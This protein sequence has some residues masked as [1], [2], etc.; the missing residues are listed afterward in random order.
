MKM[1]PTVT[2]ILAAALLAGTTTTAAGARSADA[3]AQADRPTVVLVHGAFE[4][5]TAWSYVTRRLQASGY[6]VIA[7]AVP[8]RGVGVDVAYLDSM[9]HTVQGPIV[10]VGHSYGGMLVSG[11]AALNSQVAALVYVAAFIPETGE[12]VGG[13]NSQFPGSTLGPDT[14]YT[15]DYPGGTDLYVKQESYKALYAGDRSAP[16]AAVAAAT[17]R[18]LDT[19]ALTEQTTAQAPAGTPKWA[20]VATRDKAV[21]TAAQQWEAERAGARIYR[22]CSAHDMAVSHPAE[23]ASVIEE[24]AATVRSTRSSEVDDQ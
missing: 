2:A 8:L 5:A 24:A 7:P 16:D 6:R 19:A 20:M 4:D 18:P 14:S 23:V 10:L 11:L 21:P 12:T 17:Q 9:L 22:V 15:V 13:L 3:Q 1:K